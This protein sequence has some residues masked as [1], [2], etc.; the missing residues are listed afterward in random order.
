VALYGCALYGR[1]LYGPRIVAPAEDASVLLE[2]A[3]NIAGTITGA[4]SIS[5][6]LVL[7]GSAVLGGSVDGSGVLEVDGEIAPGVPTSLLN[8][9]IAATSFRSAWTAPI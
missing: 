8:Q 4:G 5:F 3:A 9:N 7:T 1:G 6:P 2:G